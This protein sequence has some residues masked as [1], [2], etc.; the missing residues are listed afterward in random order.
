MVG[1]N[2]SHAL[3]RE[4]LLEYRLEYVVSILHQCPYRTHSC[5]FW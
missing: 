5:H 1:V 3:G 2:E 4:V